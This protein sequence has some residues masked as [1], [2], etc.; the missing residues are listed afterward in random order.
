MNKVVLFLCTLLVSQWAWAFDEQQLA[1]QL[2]AIKVLRGTFVQEKYLRGLDAPLT[3]NGEFVLAGEQGLLWN[4]QYPLVRSYRIT[5][6][7]IALRVADD[8]QQQ[9]KQDTVN[10]QS[11]LFLAVLAGDQQ[12][13]KEDFE[14]TLTGDASDW[15]LILMPQALLLQQIFDRIVIRGD[16]YVRSIELHEK[17]GDRTLM[18]MHKIEQDRVLTN[19][20]QQAFSS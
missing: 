10:R 11:R 1:E 18:R 14:L 19:D 12:G 20:E 4:L 17:Q 8:W 6:T 5:D 2:M 7:G 3:S 9:S 15:Q 16:D 13:L